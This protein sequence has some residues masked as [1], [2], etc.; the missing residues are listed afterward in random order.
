MKRNGYW[1][2]IVA[3]VLLL[4]IIVSLSLRQNKSGVEATDYASADNWLT[5]PSS[6]DLPVD[7]FYLYPTTYM[8]QAENDPTICGIDNEMMRSNAALSFN[9]QATA[10]EPVGNIYAPYYRQADPI[11]ALTMTEADRDALLSGEP[12][13]DVIAAFDYFINNYNEGR[14]FILA[15]HSQGSNMLLYL[16]SDYMKEH[17]D[18]Y[19]RMVAA[20]VI[21][22]SVTEDF[23]AKNPHLKFAK[24]PADTGVIIS[25]NT[26]AP[27]T[28][29]KNP[30]IMEGALVINPITW[31]RD[32]TQADAAE[33]LGSIMLNPDGSVMLDENG[34]FMQVKNFADAA[35]D[36]EKGAL[37]CSSVDA[38]KWAPG[39]P[40][41]PSGIFHSFDYPFYFFDIRENAKTRVQSYLGK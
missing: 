4:G 10:F 12:K 6:A 16:L 28:G 34:E 41:M 18:V 33:N 36:S 31:T 11:S 13:A 35:V 22:Y 3:I 29:G 40:L 25:Y 5:V 19:K 1:V 15:G 8:K 21:G 14:P 26:E 9:R 30:V 24:G 37:I 38:A 32:G 27:V 7:V 17:P 23:L 20:Y 39:N 2:L